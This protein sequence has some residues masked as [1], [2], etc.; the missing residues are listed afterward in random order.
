MLCRVTA[1]AELPAYTPY[2]CQRAALSRGQGSAYCPCCEPLFSGVC[3]FLPLRRLTLLPKVIVIADV[4]DPHNQVHS[5]LLPSLYSL[6]PFRFS[7]AATTCQCSL[8]SSVSP[9]ASSPRAKRYR[10]TRA[11]SRCLH[12]YDVSLRRKL[13]RFGYV[14]V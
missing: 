2:R 3:L 7:C 4:T 12:R 14:Y 6:R 5:P 11:C 9:D 10:R 8:L 1:C 13:Q